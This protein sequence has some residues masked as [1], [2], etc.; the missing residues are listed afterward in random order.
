MLVKKTK[1]K[2]KNKLEIITIPFYIFGRLIGFNKLIILF[3]D[4]KPE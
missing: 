1:D 4:Q 3:S 2:R